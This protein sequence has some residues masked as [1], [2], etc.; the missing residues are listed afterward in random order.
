[1]VTILCC[2]ERRDKHSFKR[3]G[4]NI[5]PDKKRE[6]NRILI[7]DWQH[8]ASTPASGGVWACQNRADGR[9]VKKLDGTRSFRL[10]EG[11]AQFVI[12]RADARAAS[13]A[14]SPHLCSFVPIPEYLI[15]QNSK[16]A[17]FLL[18]VLH[19]HTS[20]MNTK[21]SGGTYNDHSLNTLT[22]SLNEYLFSL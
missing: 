11:I 3:E 12:T 5:P 14:E 6:L 7:Y 20:R 2:F 19:L 10:V 13:H 16:R 1:M 17:R 15:N 8:V 22:L 21:V 9:P 4:I 18:S